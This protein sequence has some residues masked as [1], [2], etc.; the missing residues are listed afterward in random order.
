MT[1]NKGRFDW[2]VSGLSFD[3]GSLTPWEEEFIMSCDK[4]LQF[5]PELS[6][7]QEAI[8]ERIYKEKCNK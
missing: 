5:R 4:Q 6:D 2:I 7:K 8:M 3:D 1:I